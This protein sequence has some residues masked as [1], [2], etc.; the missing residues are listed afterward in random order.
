MN[1]VFVLVRLNDD[2]SIASIISAHPNHPTARAAEKFYWGYVREKH[3][4]ERTDIQEVD[5]AA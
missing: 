2:D 3:S 4:D 1:S 5:F